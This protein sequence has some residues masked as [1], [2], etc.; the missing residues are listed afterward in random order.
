[1]KNNMCRSSIKLNFSFLISEIGI[2][3]DFDWNFSLRR[4][5]F[6][7]QQYSRSSVDNIL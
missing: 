7:V 2:H 1:M 4:H 5:V 3:S 6:Y